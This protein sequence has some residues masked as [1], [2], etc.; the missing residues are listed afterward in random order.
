MQGLC[1]LREEFYFLQRFKHALP[2][3]DKRFWRVRFKVFAFYGKNFTSYSVLNPLFRSLGRFSHL[4]D[5]TSLLLHVF[6]YALMEFYFKKSFVFAARIL[7]HSE[8]N[9]KM[10][11]LNH[12][13]CSMCWKGKSRNWL[14]RGLHVH[15]LWISLP[16]M[17]KTHN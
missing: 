5:A 13:S 2:I 15:Q 3:I 8:D 10:I 11:M 4:K 9:L 16:N 14:N 1:F 7:Q 12:H 17:I 6:T